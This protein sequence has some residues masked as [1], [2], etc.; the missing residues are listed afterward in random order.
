MTDTSSSPTVVRT[1][2]SGHAVVTAR[3]G[4]RTELPI[5]SFQA[6]FAVN[7]CPSANIVVPVG[8]AAGR[9][10]SDD[11]SISDV[12]ALLRNASQIECY[13]RLKGEFAPGVK[14]P[15]EDICVFSGRVT[16]STIT[17]T[18]DGLGVSVACTHWLMDLDASNAM[19]SGMV[20]NEYVMYQMNGVTSQNIGDG[21]CF[22]DPDLNG[23]A[24]DIWTG[25]IKKKFR[26]LCESAT[27]ADQ[28]MCA[29]KAIRQSGTTTKNSKA[30][31]RLFGFTDAFD[32]AGL[33]DIPVM[34]FSVAANSIIRNCAASAVT[35]R[36]FADS[37]GKSTLL[38]KLN[39]LGGMFDFVIIPTVNSA[40]CVPLVGCLSGD[41]P[42][43]H[44]TIKPSEY[45]QIAPSD[46]LFRV[47]KGVFIVSN[48]VSAI[49]AL[50]DDTKEGRKTGHQTIAAGCYMAEQ[51]GDL[52][53]SYM[54]W[55]ADGVI[56]IVPPPPWIANV[57]EVSYSMQTRSTL[58][59]NDPATAM[60]N[61]Q[62]N[63]KSEAIAQNQA[64]LDA[65]TA[66]AQS[67]DLCSAVAKQYY[68]LEQFRHR[69]ASIVGKLRFDIAP[70]STVCVEGAD[71]KLYGES[72]T[73]DKLYGIVTGVILTVDLSSTT[74]TTA[75][76]LSHVRHQD[77]QKFGVPFHPLYGEE[78][79]W[80]GTVLQNVKMS[81]SGTFVPTVG[82]HEKA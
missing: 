68:W 32:V 61:A 14:W 73:A 64:Q 80:V 66:F 62:E 79:R 26:K 1:D 50:D 42:P 77:E 18:L 30:M 15:N 59:T 23:L 11:M 47:W 45:F 56:Q 29:D 4:G 7:S 58:P 81:G 44:V 17:R 54:D 25:G 3:S 5:T 12:T 27:L 82:N 60:S 41:P 57:K 10:S 24:D 39:E 22:V 36:M 71:A 16:G 19:D 34:K 75:F 40:A 74:A 65:E 8:K 13:L 76:T 49:G 28:L 35:Q 63:E 46:A 2:V 78:S 20:T 48:R 21:T 37:M 67:V 55:A 31:N 33:I 51:D 38:E 53:K 70:G 52:P 69:T 6:K 43:H 72:G 9:K